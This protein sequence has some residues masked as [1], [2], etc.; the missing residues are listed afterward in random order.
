MDL[1]ERKSV[2]LLS[3]AS[4]L[5]A[6]MTSEALCDDPQRELIRR[7]LGETQMLLAEFADSYFDTD[8]EAK[9]VDRS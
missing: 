7:M 5:L 6:M 3:Q 2:K 1:I 8:E 9:A 4:R